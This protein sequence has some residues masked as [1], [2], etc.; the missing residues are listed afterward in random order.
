MAIL[1]LTRLAK[2]DF[3]TAEIWNSVMDILE[4]KFAGGVSQ[5]D[6]TW[7]LTAQGDIDMQQLY[8]IVGLRKFWNV[9]NA[10]EYAT[11]DAA[12]SAVEAT[13]GGAVLIPP[14]TTISANNVS[15]DASNVQIFGYGPTSVIKITAA[16]TGPLLTTGTSGLSDISIE[17]LMLDGTGGGAGCIGVSAKRVARFR[18]NKV[19]MTAFTGDFVYLTNGGVAGQSCTDALITN[20]HCNGGSDSH[21][22][23]DDVSGLIVDNWVSKNAAGDALSM[24]PPSSSHLLQDII[25]AN[26]RVQTGGAKGM[27]ILGSGAAGIDAHSRITLA[28]N[29]VVSCTGLPYELGNTAALLKDVQVRNCFAPN[30]TTDGIRVASNRGCVA[31]CQVPAATSDGIDITNSVDLWVTG[32]NCTAAGAYGVN[33][34]TTTTCDVVG[35]NCRGAV[36]DG[37]NH[38][39]STGLRAMANEGDVGPTVGTSHHTFTSETK[40]GTTTGVFTTHSHTVRANSLKTGDVLEIC[41]II[42]TASGGTT[43]TLAIKIGAT[44]LKSLTLATTKDYSVRCLVRAN[45]GGNSDTAFTIVVEDRTPAAVNQEIDFGSPA[46]TWTTDQDVT[47]DLTAHG[48]SGDIALARTSIFYHGSK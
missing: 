46:V 39:G 48:A 35:N 22:V 24:V 20:L 27:R 7:P 25:I 12:I 17:N 44:T 1:G 42:Q 47:F 10:D 43:G 26:S 45:T 3:L 6:I 31:G 40:S 41:A 5:S 21:I 36:T 4:A 32:N 30:S 8:S 15:I 19:Y 2:K 37:V 38:T 23:A 29:H 11:L 9:V 18:M 14:Y 16:A 33:A 13:G 34:N 28:N